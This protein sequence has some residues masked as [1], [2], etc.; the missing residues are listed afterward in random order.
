[1]IWKIGSLK[2]ILVVLVIAIMQALPWF[3]YRKYFQ[4]IYEQN[5][6]ITIAFP[7][8]L[9]ILFI[10]SLLIGYFLVKKKLTHLIATLLV[11]ALLHIASITLIVI[12]HGF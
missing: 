9:C 1:M 7:L 3:A 11:T 4:T 5:F 10:C 6:N 8:F 2:F 12:L